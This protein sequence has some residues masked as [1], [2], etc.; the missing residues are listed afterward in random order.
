[1]KF[2]KVVDGVSKYLSD[3][4][5]PT[6]VIWQKIIVADVVS[7]A[8]RWAEAYLNDPQT[9][10]FLRAL[11]YVDSD[12]N[13]DVE[14]VLIGLKKYIAEKD[15]KWKIEIPLMPVLVFTESDVD[16]LFEYIKKEQ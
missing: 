6:M 11:S 12:D 3:N 10:T 7:R 1:M 13:I 8:I 5:Y 4:I 9:C 2:E 15:G 14:G 16:D